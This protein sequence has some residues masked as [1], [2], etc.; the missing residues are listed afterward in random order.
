[1]I[2]LLKRFACIIGWHSF[3]YDFVESPEDPLYTHICDKYKCKWCGY[4]GMLDSQGNLF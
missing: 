1:M 3:S 4:V 2:K